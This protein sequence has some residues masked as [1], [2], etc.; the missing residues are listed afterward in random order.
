MNEGWQNV[1]GI[2]PVYTCPEAANFHHTIA[3]SF[4]L[5]YK[6]NGFK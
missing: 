2:K 3:L 6:K 1:P 5:H 4:A